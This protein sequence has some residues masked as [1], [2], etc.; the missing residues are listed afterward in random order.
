MSPDPNEIVGIL[1]QE[2]GLAFKDAATART[3]HNELKEGSN[4]VELVPDGV[5]PSNSFRLTAQFGWRHLEVDFR[6]GNFAGNLIR[7]MGTAGSLNRRLFVD[8]VQRCVHE[9]ATIHLL[10]NDSPRSYDDGSIWEIPWN[11]FEFG[12]RKGQLDLDTND[13]AQMQALVNFWMTL[14]ITS[15]LPLLTTEHLNDE[16]NEPS[17]SGYPEGALLRTWVNKFERDPRNRAAALAIHG[18]TCVVCE[19]DLAERYGPI[20]SGFVEVHHI[21]PVS[22]VGHDYIVDPR[23]DLVPLCPNCHAIA[24]RKNPPFSIHELRALY[25]QASSRES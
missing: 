16:Y 21:T 7:E 11:N 24:H 20:G 13:T 8:G 1:A 6:P 22:E 14:L 23:T 3:Y 15:I 17:V 12:I 25:R 9:G 10:I 2:T 19:R 5:S 18:R 4:T